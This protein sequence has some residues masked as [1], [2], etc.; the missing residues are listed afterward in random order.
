M[1]EH[2]VLSAIVT[3]LPSSASQAYVEYGD[4]LL[5]QRTSVYQLFGSPVEIPLLGLKPQTTYRCRAV[6]VY[7]DGSV[8][9]GR[10]KT[11]TTGSLP[12]DLPRFSITVHGSP[13]PGFVM[14]GTISTAE[15]R[16][17]YAMIV[18]D[19]GRVVWY[20]KFNGSIVDFQKQPGGTYTAFI[21]STVELPRFFEFDRLGTVL[22]DYYASGGV[23]TG[24]H[25][26]RVIRTEHY[27]FGI[28]HRV[29][30]LRSIGGR[31]NAIVRGIVVEHMNA[32]MPVLRW[33]S[34][35][36]FLVVDAA[37][38]I[39]LTGQN[40]N[41]WHGNAI[42]IDRDGHLLV[43][44][45]NLDEITKINGQAGEIIWR[46]GGR[47][48][49]FTFINDPLNGFSHQHGIRRLPNGNIILFDN[50]NLHTPPLSR[51]VEYRLDEEAKTAELVWEYR[52]NP[53]LHGFAL[54]FA[55]RLDNGNTLIT[56]GTEPRI[57]EVDP[58]GEKRWELVLDDPS[59]FA[60]RAFRIDS[61]Y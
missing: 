40:V 28:E 13:L 53:P 26:L 7:A 55:Q 18:D 37:P 12:S 50:G 51:P 54:G 61:L 9:P 8:S 33:N 48:N 27:L 32:G 49:Q 23:E 34:F 11:F 31:S 22:R 15:T 1:N 60:Y 42:E 21:S 20:R 43:S 29:M 14:F 4:S 2:N 3:L 35:D 36:H 46:L 44:F 17:Y 16:K 5:D 57:I 56:Y 30:D 10:T 47:N 19:A 45:R 25:E 58:T 6:A 39:D 59:H 24:P 52:H 38:D 41:P